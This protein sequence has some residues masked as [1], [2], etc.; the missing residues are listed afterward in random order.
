MDDNP[1][2]KLR[3]FINER[4]AVVRSNPVITDLE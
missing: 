1:I 3:G 4:W 2:A